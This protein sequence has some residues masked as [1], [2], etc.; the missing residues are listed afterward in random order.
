MWIPLLFMGT[1]TQF[2]F[3][4]VDPN[5]VSKQ[6]GAATSVGEPTNVGPAARNT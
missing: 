5:A 3:S 1:S 6:A 4:I 2:R